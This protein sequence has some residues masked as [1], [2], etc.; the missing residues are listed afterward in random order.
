MV[1]EF[2]GADCMI[3][4]YAIGVQGNNLVDKLEFIVQRYTEDG[5]DLATYTPYV[6]LQNT[7]EKYFDK[8]N[9]VKIE[10]ADEE[11]RLTYH[12]R[13]KTTRYSQFDLQLQFEHYNE[14]EADNQIWQTRPIT[15]FLHGTIPADEEIENEY[16][17]AISDLTERVEELEENSVTNIKFIDGGTP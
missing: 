3:W 12:L 7:R 5:I 17:S 9:K 2:D 11:L 14:E 10:T 13:R 6:K 1:I 8:D 15:F 16:P 4:R